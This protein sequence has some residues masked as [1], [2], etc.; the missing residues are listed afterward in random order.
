MGRWSLASRVASLARWWVEKQEKEKEGRVSDGR[1]WGE[2]WSRIRVWEEGCVHP[3][4][5]HSQLLTS[6]WLSVFRTLPQRNSL[7]VVDDSVLD[8]L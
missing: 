2:G 7:D 4:S 1:Y 8:L 5:A 3:R 6:R